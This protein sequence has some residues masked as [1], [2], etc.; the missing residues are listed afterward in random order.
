MNRKHQGTTVILALIAGLAG[1]MISSAFLSGEAVFADKQPGHQ[2]AVRAEL[3]ELVDEE[4]NLRGSLGERD[5]SVV[6]RLV[7]KR[8]SFLNAF[9]GRR[10]ATVEF[11]TYAKGKIDMRV[12]GN[13]LQV[14]LFDQLEP[15]RIRAVLGNVNLQHEDTG[16]LEARAPSSLVLFDEGG[17]VVWKGP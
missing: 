13:G 16:E 17:K 10:A 14:R 9:L 4:G 12:D 7:G 1:G 3:F 6:L 8:S 5:G 15:P 11:G 2:T